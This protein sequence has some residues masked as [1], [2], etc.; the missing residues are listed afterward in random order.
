M[1]K[2]Y[3]KER[4]GVLLVAED[5]VTAGVPLLESQL[6]L[7]VRRFLTKLKNI[8]PAVGWYVQGHMQLGLRSDSRFLQLFFPLSC[9][10]IFSS[11]F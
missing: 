6:P 5:E 1:I 3:Q 11:F 8:W 2:Q 10:S 4:E 7:Q 9:I